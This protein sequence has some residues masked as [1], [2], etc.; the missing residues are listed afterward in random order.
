MCVCVCDEDAVVMRMRLRT[1]RGRRWMKRYIVE[2]PKIRALRE[3]E[4]Q[5]MLYRVDPSVRFSGSATLRKSWRVD[6]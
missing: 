2:H 3:E 1:A 6:L 5:V 4:E